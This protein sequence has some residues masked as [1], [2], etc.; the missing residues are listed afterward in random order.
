M[1]DR[2]FDR[3]DEDYGDVAKLTVLLQ[4]EPD[5]VHCRDSTKGTLLD[6]AS[7][8]G[9]SEAVE[10][11]LRKGAEVNARDSTGCTPLHYASAPGHHEVVELLLANG[12]DARELLG[13]TPLWLGAYNGHSAVVELLLAKGAGLNEKSNDGSTPLRAIRLGQDGRF[14]L[15]SAVAGYSWMGFYGSVFGEFGRIAFLLQHHGGYE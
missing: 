1:K 5:V 11:L 4:E 15:E 3:R 6:I 2:S 8:I 10:L 9:R 12:V 13:L 7:S 14:R